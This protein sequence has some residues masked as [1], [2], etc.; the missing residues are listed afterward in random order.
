[1]HLQEHSCGVLCSPC[2]QPHKPQVS[3]RELT[4]CLS[5]DPT[6][7]RQPPAQVGQASAQSAA[8]QMRRS[9]ATFRGAQASKRQH[10]QGHQLADGAPA[11]ALHP[12][13]RPWPDLAQVPHAAGEVGLSIGRVVGHP[14]NPVNIHRLRNSHSCRTGSGVPVWPRDVSGASTGSDGLWAAQQLAAWGHERL[15]LCGRK[16]SAAQPP[17]CKP[18]SLGFARS[19]ATLSITDMLSVMRNTMCALG[20]RRLRPAAAATVGAAGDGTVM[21]WCWPTSRSSR[22]PGSG[23]TA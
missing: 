12:Q 21:L 22:R 15:P 16:L 5:A 8:V 2:F 14:S 20:G 19:C 1:M 9:S 10:G 23:C 17:T 11:S 7:H 4:C 6:P 3:P 18:L 13:Q